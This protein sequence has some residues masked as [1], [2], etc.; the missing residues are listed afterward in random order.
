MNDA[1]VI[2]PDYKSCMHNICACKLYI[3]STLLYGV[4]SVWHICNYTINVFTHSTVFQFHKH[5]KY[6]FR[7]LL[8]YLLRAETR[9]SMN[10]HCLRQ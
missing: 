2:Q 4:H 7:I 1:K 9:F 8:K 6:M 5:N 10:I 3:H